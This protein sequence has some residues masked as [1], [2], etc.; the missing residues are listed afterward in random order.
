MSDPEYVN[1]CPGC[2]FA[3]GVLEGEPYSDFTFESD[4]EF[5]QFFKAADEAQTN[6]IT[7]YISGSTIN[8]EMPYYAFKS[9][10]AQAN[11][12]DGPVEVR[13][14]RLGGLLGS[15]VVMHC[16]MFPA[17]HPAKITMTI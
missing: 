11:T 10:E 16:G 17:Q 5:R 13:K 3:K 15:R 8:S 14:Q 6:K 9:V 2:P 4:A 1:F 7:V 12:C